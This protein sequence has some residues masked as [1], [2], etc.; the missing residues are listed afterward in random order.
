VEETESALDEI[1][2]GSEEATLIAEESL[3]SNEE[4][5][6]L[7]LTGRTVSWRGRPRDLGPTRMYLKGRWWMEPIRLTLGQ[8]KQRCGTEGAGILTFQGT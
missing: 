1:R 3:V 5:D 6:S 7:E 4:S 8:K 2:K